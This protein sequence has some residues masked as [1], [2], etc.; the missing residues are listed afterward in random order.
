MRINS[1]LHSLAGLALRSFVVL[2][3]AAA[4][5]ACGGGG[6]SD[7]GGA[8]V[9]TTIASIVVVD[10]DGQ[11]ATVGTELSRA[12]VVRVLNAGGTPIPGATVSFVVVSGGG[13]LFA[14]SSTSDSTGQARERWTMGVTAA[15]AQ[16]VEARAVGGGGA[17]LTAR[18]NAVAVAG[19]AVRLV[20]KSGAN[21]SSLQAQAQPAPVVVAVEDVH[22]NPVAGVQVSF[23]VNGG[24]T[25]TP[26]AAA[27]DAAGEI[28]VVW[29]LG[30]PLGAQRLTAT[31][32]GLAALEVMA[33][34]TQA[35]PGVPTRIVL[36]LGDMQTVLQHALLPQ[37]LWAW[38]TDDLGN[39]VPGVTV[40]FAP[41]AGGPYFRTGTAVTTTPAGDAGGYVQWRGYFHTAG[42]QL[43]EASVSPTV[44]MTFTVNVTP[45]AFT[46][47]GFY[48]C[49]LVS[50]S[51]ART[52][53][54]GITMRNGAGS[55]SEYA[56][57]SHPLS[58]TPAAGGAGAYT[59]NYRATGDY[60]WV[61]TG[62]FAAD[63]EGRAS[64]SGTFIEVF[65]FTTP[66]GNTGTWT[67]QRD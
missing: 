27:S 21:Q 48:D 49:D 36:S 33:N 13:T 1:Y 5:G 26:G 57:P 3:G 30:I 24:G 34:A 41:V 56:D 28:R 44:K 52:I 62:T 67:C 25:V 42:T 19:P 6:G 35:P 31:A 18:F 22:N 61:L 7:S 47:D 29:T 39:G 4:I 37:P 8:P 17:A 12:L 46:L 10:G 40:T 16:R 38:V 32:Q 51:P 15:Q 45:S 59:G 50:L 58:F 55:G 60:N 43:V 65:H 2:L 11:T 66:T 53:E 63:A 23:A 54:A 9:D 14:G 20:A 64:G